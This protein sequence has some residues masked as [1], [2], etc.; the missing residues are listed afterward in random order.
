MGLGTI[1]FLAVGLSMDAFA[2]SISSGTRAR[3]RLFWTALVMGL[4]FGAFQ[5]L[6]PALGSAV[7]WAA[8]LGLRNVITHYDHWIAFL[9]LTAL[10]GKMIYEVI[11]DWLAV[12]VFRYFRA[13][14]LFRFF[15]SDEEKDDNRVLSLTLGLLLTLSIATSIDALAV[16]F[17]FS[18]IKMSIL[19][20]VTIIGAVTFAFSMSGVF[21]GSKCGECFGKKAEFAG[22]LILIVIGAKILLAHLCPAL[23]GLF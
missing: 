9:L 2:V 12:V 14:R 16:G 23:P 11:R 5:A 1:L 20:P 13:R 6:M 18:A 8:N 22:G 15:R 4:F 21:I 17:T 19:R 7:G 10:G 3:S